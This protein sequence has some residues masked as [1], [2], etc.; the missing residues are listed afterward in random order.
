MILGTVGFRAHENFSVVDESETLASGISLDEFDV[1][2][3]NPDGLEVSGLVGT[4]ITE[5]GNGHYRVEFIPDQVGTWYMVVYHP[6]FFPWGKSDDI[7][8]YMGDP[9]SPAS[10]YPVYIPISPPDLEIK[11]IKLPDIRTKK[12]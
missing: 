8:V 11:E 5:L 9:S 1:D 6:K 12:L 4:S 2:L 3:F 10:S 7:Q